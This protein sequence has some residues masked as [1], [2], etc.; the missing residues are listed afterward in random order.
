[1]KLCLVRLSALG[2]VVLM[3]PL[4][5]TLQA[6]IPNLELTWITSPASYSILEGLS[7]VNFLVIDKPNSLGDY[8]RFYQRMKTES[9]DVL[10]AAQA[11]FRANLLYPLIKAKRKIGFDHGRSK[12][13]HRFFIQ[14]SI[15]ARQEHLLEGFLG[16]ARALGI[17][18]TECRW[19]L[20]LSAADHAF[21][22]S[23]LPEGNWLA[24][25]PAASKP[26]R[27]WLSSRYAE[28][29]Q[30]AMEEWGMRV[31]L[32]GGP[33]EEEKRLANEVLQQCK[34]PTSILNLVGATTPKQC[35]AVLERAR[36]LLSPDTGP[37]HIAT[38]VGTPVVG[39]YAV[40]PSMLSGPYL[41]KHFVIDEFANAVQQLLKRDP[42]TVPWGTRVHDPKAMELIEVESVLM[43]LRAVMA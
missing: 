5:R 2:D 22:E 15:E 38:A 34:D 40:A 37:A 16:F 1:M 26:E 7:G 10:L 4:V 30:T 9:F 32:T 35:A 18:K 42:N 43:K 6:A 20:A 25:N 24:V 13:G 8:W 28:V 33:G 36:V 17:E 39:L 21:A 12:D 23:Q 41:S 29:I 3:I 11:S 19:D 27:N 14:E 31:V